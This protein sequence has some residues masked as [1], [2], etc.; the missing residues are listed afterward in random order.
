VDVSPLVI[1]ATPEATLNAPIDAKCPLCG[2]KSSFAPSAGRELAKRVIYP[3]HVP[4]VIRPATPDEELLGAERPA[5]ATERT[6]EERLERIRRELVAG[7]D[8]L[9]ELG[10][11]VSIFGSAR[12]PPDHPDC[13]LARETAHRLGEAGFAVIT[14][15]GPGIMAAANRGAQDAR[16]TSVGLNIDLP[17]EQAPNPFQDVELR[18]HYFFTRKIMF[19]R[20]ASAFVVF[21]G[22]FGTLDELFE[23]LLLIQTRKI[24]H[25]P[26]V[27]VRTAFWAG[28]TDWLR[29]RL[30]ADAMIAPADLELFTA[31]DDPD[32][33][34]ALV[35]AGARRQ[36]LQLAA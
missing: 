6:E 7:Y 8:A 3:R 19:V 21:P 33:V 18:F 24:R 16:T 28:M 9:G 22:G 12:T 5:V 2:Q 36:G 14:G 13:A 29:D 31:T 35:R 20:Y 11:A 30:A 26:V 17:F 32:E 23:A 27:L 15:G 25:F 4:D 34:V 1:Q 10:C